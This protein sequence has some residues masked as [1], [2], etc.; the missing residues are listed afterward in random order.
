MAKAAKTRQK[1]EKKE[2]AISAA[3]PPPN[4]SL[5]PHLVAFIDILG[6]GHEIKAA[7]QMEKLQKAHAKIRKVQKLF[8]HPSASNDPE[9]QLE[10]NTDYG[11]KVIA[12]SDAVVVA[13][14]PNCPAR[15]AM[16]GYDV[17]GSAVFEL[18]VAQA[19]CALAGIFVRGGISHGPFFYENDILLSPALARAYELESKCAEYPIIVVPESTRAALLKAS[20]VKDY[21]PNADPLQSCFATFSTRKW[22]GEQLFFLDYVSIMLEEEHIGWLPEDRKDY[23][24]ARRRGDQQRERAALERRTLKDQAYSLKWHKWKLENAYSAAS[25]EKVRRKYRWL[26]SYH[27]RCFNHESR[28][29]RNHVIDLSK[30]KSDK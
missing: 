30:F 21:A 20:G 1:K 13:V 14:T 7:K 15:P 4:L 19:Y 23:L 16:S 26:M 17:L 25:S 28:Y 5:Q 8:Q 9:E 11:R 12:L 27:N 18:A 29:L 3:K 24:D 10:N 2:A 22:A 6:F